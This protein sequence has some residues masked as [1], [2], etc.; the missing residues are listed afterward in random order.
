MNILTHTA[1]VVLD[2]KQLPAIKILKSNHKAQDEKERRKQD[3]QH[4]TELCKENKLFTSNCCDISDVIRSEPS[5]NAEAQTSYDVAN[6]HAI[7]EENKGTG[8][9]LWDIF[10]REDVP[11]LEAYLNKY[12]NEFRH[13]YGSRVEQV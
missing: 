11:K 13:T 6:S 9:A 7:S 12:F 5:D 4:L 8:G 10:R 3:E 2:D 1:D